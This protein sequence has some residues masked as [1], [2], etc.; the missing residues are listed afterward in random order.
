MAAPLA[1]F[2]WAYYNKA[3]AS[4]LKTYLPAKLNSFLSYFGGTR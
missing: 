3:D 2:A 1:N 4:V